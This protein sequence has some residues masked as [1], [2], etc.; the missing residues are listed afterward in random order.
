MLRRRHARRSGDYLASL[1]ALGLT[2]RLKRLSDRML[3]EARLLYRELELHVEPNWHLVFLLLEERGQLSVTEIAGALGWTHPSVVK[4]T[5]QMRA[6]GLLE[7]KG[8][9]GDRR[10]TLLRLSA[11]GRAQLAAARPIWDAGRRGLEELIDDAGGGILPA[12]AALE[13]AVAERGFRRRTLAALERPKAR[14]ARRRA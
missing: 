8:Q 9:P 10:R 12:L 14:P 7:A 2:A 3:H 6:Q 4:V 13:A 11:A 5:S 1:G